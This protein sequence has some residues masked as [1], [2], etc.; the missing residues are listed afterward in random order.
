MDII[1][2][3]PLVAIRCFTYNHENYIEDALKG[4]VM[5]K[6]DFPFTAIVV[7]DASTDIEPEVLWR[8]VNNELNQSALQRD[9]TDDYIRVVA[10]HKTNQNCTF[11]VL[12]LKYNHYSIKKSK[13]P[14]YKEWHES[15]KY[16]A[17]C[18]GDDYWTDPNKIQKQ[19]DFLES[20]PDYTMVCNR[21]KLYSEKQKKYIGENYC[22]NHNRTVKTKDVIYRSGLFIST[23]SIMYRK[24]L[25]NDCP[26][27]CRK[28]AV[29]D[30][31]LQI[32]A[33]MKGKVY[34]FNDIMSVYRVENSNSWMKQQKWGTLHETNLHRIISMINMFKGFSFDYPIYK[35]YFSNKISHYYI[36]QAP[37]RFYNRGKDIRYYI[38][39]FQKDYNLF[40]LFWK[41]IVRLSTSNI[42]IIRGYYGVYTKSL[43]NK[44]KEKIYIYK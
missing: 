21:T 44:Y 5:Q 14:Y 26:D 1:N 43:F 24:S 13:Y 31:P 36:S 6:T 40:P 38:K 11:I 33:A 37:E 30:Y 25:Q 41:I 20:H 3:T 28:C 23:C 32:M 2:P 4:F 27:Y 12:F 8:F 7:D 34:Y 35:K 15:A 9:E 10:P 17:L 16:I 18:E 29:G 39:Y 22:Y 42:P 19:I